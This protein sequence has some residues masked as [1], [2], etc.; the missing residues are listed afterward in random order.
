MIENSD[1]QT[2]KVADAVEYFFDP[3]ATYVSDPSSGGNGGVLIVAANV[4]YPL[5]SFV[6]EAGGPQEGAEELT[7]RLADL[8]INA[9]GN[10]TAI[11]DNPNAI[12][13]MTV[14]LY[15]GN[16]TPFNHDTIVSDIP[17]L[18]IDKYEESASQIEQTFVY[19]GTAGNLADVVITGGTRDAMGDKIS[20][21]SV[22]IL[23]Y[24]VLDD[25]IQSGGTGAGSA[26][27]TSIPEE[28]V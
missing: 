12:I 2:G 6:N 14:T 24:G 7:I 27:S 17:G 4:N 21:A 20:G 26:G 28:E 13:S 18:R 19:M 10:L 11:T 8:F 1:T 22:F 23:E 15:G 16:S 9:K 5:V 3:E 25:A